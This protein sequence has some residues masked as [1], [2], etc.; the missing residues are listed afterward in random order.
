MIEKDIEGA[1]VDVFNNMN[2]NGLKVTGLWQP[3]AEGVVKGLEKS[4]SVAG[5]VVKIPPKS[6]DTFGICEVQ[7]DIQLVLTVRIEKDKS[8]S[9]LMEFVEPI[10][11]KLE[12][13]NLVQVGEEL[14]D[15]KVEG[16]YPG[17]VQIQ[18]GSGPDLDRNLTTWTVQWNVTLRGT[19]EH[20]ETTVEE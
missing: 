5:L 4:D 11:A 10:N 3:S 17:G 12:E 2:L 7:F 16:F 15:F 1:L 14:D 9:H 18:A 6:F 20:G 8:G 13:W 19:L